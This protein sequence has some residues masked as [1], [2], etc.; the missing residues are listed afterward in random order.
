MANFRDLPRIEVLLQRPDDQLVPRVHD[1][2]LLEVGVIVVLAVIA[3]RGQV[4]IGEQAVAADVRDH[5]LGFSDGKTKSL[6]IYC[7]YYCISI[8]SLPD[9]IFLPGSNS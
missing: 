9:P 1:Q 6:E 3:D 5:I 4:H 7:F 2:R 8:V